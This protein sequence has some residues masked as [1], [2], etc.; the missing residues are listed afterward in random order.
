VRNKGAFDDYIRNLQGK[1]D[2]GTSLE[3]AIGMF[4]CDNLKRINDSH[5]HD[6]GDIYLKKAS[7]LI[8]KVFQH[9]PVFRVGGDEF[10]VVLM[11][12]DFKNRVDL[13]NQFEDRQKESWNTAENKWQEVRVAFGVAVYDS[14]KDQSVSDTIRRADKIM[15]ENKRQGK[16]G[17]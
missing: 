6:K 3:F 4:D 17:L 8:C 9:S 7:M 11:N 14:I 12:E 2:G 16:A 10:A 1:L 15:Y 5:G 13:M